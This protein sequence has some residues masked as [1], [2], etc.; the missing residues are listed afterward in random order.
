MS[1]NVRYEEGTELSTD[2]ILKTHEVPWES[3]TSLRLISDRDAQLIRKYDKRKRDTQAELLEQNGPA[4]C[5]AFLNVLRN[6]TKEEAVQYVLA[7]IDDLLSVDPA[8]AQ[9]FHQE[10]DI[11]L[12]TLPDPYSIFLRLLNKTDWFTQAK[13]AKALTAILEARPDKEP[14]VLADGAPNEALVSQGVDHAM[15]T[16]IEWLCSQLR[17]P[18]NPTHSVPAAIHCLCRLLRERSVRVLF[19]RVS[20]SVQL[21][22]PLLRSNASATAPNQQL[23]YEAGMCVWQLTFY[24]PAAQAMG[25]SGVVQG[26]VDMA[27]SAT[28]EKVWRVAM[29]A[30][31]NLLTD[32]KLELGPE[33]VEAGLPKVVQQRKTQL[34]DDEELGGALDSLDVSLKEN[35]QMLSSFEKYK[36]EVLGDS[37]DWTPMHTSQQFW[38]ENVEKFEE[39]DFQILRVLLKLLEASRETRTLAVGCHDLGM[40]ITSHPHGRSIV[41]E[42]RGKELVMRLMM[43]PEPEVQKQALL[44]VQKIMLAK[45][46]LEYLNTN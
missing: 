11:H 2:Q 31:R 3:F 17:R 35:I 20:G 13:A 46:K 24:E 5:Q 42:F 36:K 21:L 26:L 38:K 41:T 43:H 30:L 45:D 23:L 33:M 12:A 27:R 15:K 19:Q 6:V 18:F 25:S 40:F 7:L 28:K 9:L 37:L 4:Y 32:D 34:K 44:C 1:R 10:S 29:L 39:K 14:F 16:F 22:A 8:R